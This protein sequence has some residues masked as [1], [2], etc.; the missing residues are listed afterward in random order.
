MES[1]DSSSGQ[2]GLRQEVLDVLRQGTVI[3]AH[4]LALDASRQ[5]DERR[6]RALSRYYLA[7]GAGGLAVGVHTTQFQIHDP[8]VGLLEPVWTLAAEELDRAGADRAKPPVR[9][10]GICGETGQAVCEATLA[11]DL[12]YH[13]GLLNLNA[14]AGQSIDQLITHCRSVADSIS[15][16]GFYL[17]PAAGGML[18]PYAFWR[19]FC[20]IENVRAIKIAPFNR[21]QTIDVVRAVAE[22]GRE[23]IAL[24]T[25][26]DDNIVLDLLTPYRFLKDNQLVE[27]RIVGGLL[28]H[29]SV[30]TSKAVELFEQ[31]HEVV[32]RCNRNRGSRGVPLDM[33]RLNLAVTDC[34][35]VLFD[36]ANGF[37]G[38]I[39]GIHEVLRRQGL[40]E[41]IGCL[42]ENEVLSP[43]QAAELDR[44]ESAYP[45][46]IDNDFVAEHRDE[47]LSG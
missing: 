39:P 27:R 44:I 14:L 43:G 4:P 10:A 3:P 32:H 45:D 9:V 33:L 12:G 18:L 24:Y 37:S 20:E 41:G 29:W 34:N 36:V 31:C 19:K 25:G 7:S 1:T 28:G 13:L 16:F 11:R 46:L 35:A 23:D 2:D 42:D 47:W 38:C 22:S 15:L 40:L 17:Q 21:Y 8:K 6:Q 5:L 26:N 30:W